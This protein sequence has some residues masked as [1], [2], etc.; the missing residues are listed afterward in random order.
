[1]RPHWRV[2]ALSKAGAA[3]FSYASPGTGSTGHIGIEL[4]KTLTRV[5]DLQQ[6]PHRGA[7]VA[8]ADVLSGRIRLMLD[9]AMTSLAMVRNGRLRGLAAASPKR[10]TF[11]PEIPAKGD[12]YPRLR[13][14][15][16]AR[17]RRPARFAA[18]DPRPP[19]P[20]GSAGAGAAA[21]RRALQGAGRGTRRNHT[22]RVQA[23]HRGR[24]GA[25]GPD[26]PAIWCQDRVIRPMATLVQNLTIG[27]GTARHEVDRACRASCSSP[28]FPP[29]DRFPTILG[30]PAVNRAPARPIPR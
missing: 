29:R 22:C 7:G 18:G 16:L 6:V 23:P 17:H 1:M 9:P 28:T 12:F 27:L 8:M 30:T 20:R 26:H 25:L 15:L 21:H 19:V 3:R 2:V 13:R 24:S 5:T 11:A 10:T 4:F 14:D